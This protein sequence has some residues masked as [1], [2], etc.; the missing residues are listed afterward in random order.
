MICYFDLLDIMRKRPLILITAFMMVYAIPINIIYFLFG[1]LES[2]KKL[3]DVYSIFFI[4]LPTLALGMANGLYFLSGFTKLEACWKA[5]RVCS[6]VLFFSS[7][8]LAFQFHNFRV[9]Q[10]WN[11]FSTFCV[12]FFILFLCAVSIPF[13]TGA[14][15]LFWLKKGNTTS[16]QAHSK[17]TIFV[18]GFIVFYLFSDISFITFYDMPY[19]HLCEDINLFILLGIPALILSGSLVWSTKKPFSKYQIYMIMTITAFIAYSMLL[20]GIDHYTTF[21]FYSNF[22]KIEWIYVIYSVGITLFFTRL[23]LTSF[24][25][26]WLNK[27][28]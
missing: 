5:L 12:L 1:Y 3:F 22:A 25:P 2:S 9:D 18:T 14:V 16:F 28:I 17:V 13:L 27:S 23:A 7:I 19:P 26:V 8:L 6:S 11:I 15:L 21:L 20:Y 24:A 10:F 4:T